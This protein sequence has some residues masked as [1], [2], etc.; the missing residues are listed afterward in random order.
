MTENKQDDGAELVERELFTHMYVGR[1]DRGPGDV[2]MLTAEQV[3]R[4]EAMDP[5]AV[6]AVGT[7]ERIA[8]E[9]AE[10]E[11]ADAEAAEQERA[12]RDE[13][14]A[15]RRAHE[16]NQ[17]AAEAEKDDSDEGKRSS[18]SAVS[19]QDGPRRPRSR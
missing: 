11:E 18:T 2:V 6:G 12:R 15:R 17:P 14:A 10:A 19:S 9:Q 5:P 1:V 4:L 7:L 3:E 8:K 13:G 16:S